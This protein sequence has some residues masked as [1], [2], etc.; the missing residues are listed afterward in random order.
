MDPENCYISIRGDSDAYQG[1]HQAIQAYYL[2]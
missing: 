1:H 2:M